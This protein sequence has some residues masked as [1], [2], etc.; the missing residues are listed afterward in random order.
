[1]SDRPARE[2]DASSP[3]RWEAIE[4][5][6][7]QALDL[8]R[9]QRSHFL[10]ATCEDDDVLHRDVR[11]LLDSHDAVV[12]SDGTDNAFLENLDSGQ[13]AA[14]VQAPEAMPPALRDA[15]GDR[16][17]VERSI[18]TGG[19]AEVFAARDVRH[20]R[21]VAIKIVRQDRCTPELD[22]RFER[23]VRIAAR[24]Q[25]PHIVPLY[26]S[27]LAGGHRYYVMP[28]VDGPSLRLRLESGTS[29]AV[30]E[31]LRIVDDVSGAL[32]YAHASG[33]VHRDIKPEN[34]LLSGGH[35]VV[36]DF[37][38]ARPVVEAGEPSTFTGAGVAVGTPA[39]MSPEQA[40]GERALDG[41]C[42]QYAL[43]CSAYEL[44]TGRPPYTGQ[45]AR[46]IIAQ[47][48]VAP[49]PSLGLAT[50]PAFRALDEVMGRALAKDPSARFATTAEF[51]GALRGASTHAHAADVPTSPVRDPSLGSAPG[52]LMPLIGRDETLA[53]AMT[54]I[55]RA[56]VRLVTF[57]GTG[58][59]G[60]TR[61]AREVGERLR[62]SFEGGV[63]FVPL[64]HISDSGLVAPTIGHALGLHDQG[65]KSLLDAFVAR[66]GGRRLLLVLDNLEQIIAAASWIVE[67]LERVPTLSVL[68]TSRVLLR[69]HGEHE[70]IVPPLGVPDLASSAEVRAIAASPSVQLFV[71]R[72]RAVDASFA[73]T[74]ENAAAVA[75]IC[76]RLDGLP[77]AIELAAARINLLAPA[78]I[79]GRLEHRLRLLT[80]GARDRPER[81]QTLRGAIGWSYDLLGEVERTLFAR[82]SVFA[83][84]CTVEAAEIV[85]GGERLE[86]E[87]LDGI[88]ALLDASLLQREGP[89]GQAG[90]PRLRMLETIREFALEM[91]ARDGHLGAVRDR[92]CDWFLDLA[93]RA[94]PNLTGT[95]QERWLA[96]LGAEHANLQAALGRTMQLGDAKRGLSFGASL[97]RYWLVRGHAREGADWLDQILA[98]PADAPTDSLRATALTGAGTLAQVLSD[99][100][101]STTHLSSALEMRRQLRD[102]AGEARALAD[103]GWVAWRRCEYAEARRVSH[104]SLELS[105]T[106]GEKGLMASALSNLG[107]VA[108]FEGDYRASNEALERGL[109]LRRELA[110][111]RGIAY[112]LMSLEWTASRSD[113]CAR[114]QPL[115]D[116]VLPIFRAIGDRRLYAAAF[117]ALAR[118][119]FRRGDLERA[120]SILESEVLPIMRH[121]NDRWNIGVALSLLS[122]VVRDEGDISRAETLAAESIQLRRSISD[123]HGLAESLATLGYAA[124]ARLDGARARRLF[125]ESL[126][127]RR[128]IGDCAGIV[129][130]ER[131]LTALACAEP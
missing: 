61:L 105:R 67:L 57:T 3:E 85:C 20:D 22:D 76:V 5:V 122:R 6:F 17:V 1:V 110:D 39:Y 27:G 9:D 96:V 127:V 71:E 130:C 99:L 34:I 64:A 55:G 111:G 70:L 124:V 8:E 121:T 108:M 98:L 51:A 45:T 44:L 30:D 89:M 93:R 32:D 117:S 91:L 103:I 123:R 38:V 97:W 48:F 42:D 41:R 107:W 36:V 77:L 104:E 129:E 106:L 74:E 125:T 86:T 128:A 112:M 68:V 80:R 81:H 2:H 15:L 24:L 83:G 21:M 46:A 90:G 10:A 109:S 131:E 94:A 60:K 26:D 11:D 13:A 35:A 72:A 73:L 113:D 65:S 84:G 78:A 118:A 53:A 56:D 100:E 126:S 54:L 52:R 19:M 16:Y 47:H 114:T 120:R 75:E 101:T 49:V 50:G 115:A 92:H 59:T 37:G 119:C 116:E 14:L 62:G 23:E 29:Y 102:G 43:A 63:W 88:D 95:E 40:A 28:L 7:K 12:A 82:L 58:G 69:V 25:H 18:G 79:V 66:A 87:V 33:I 31:V 4:R